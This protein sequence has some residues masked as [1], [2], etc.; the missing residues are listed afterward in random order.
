MGESWVV[1]HHRGSK[2]IQV[3]K[4]TKPAV[5]IGG[6][7]FW[8]TQLE[9]NVSMY[10]SI[11]TRSI[12]ANLWFVNWSKLAI[13]SKEWTWH[14]KSQMRIAHSFQDPWHSFPCFSAPEGISCSWFLTQA[15]LKRAEQ[16]LKLSDSFG[17]DWSQGSPGSPWGDDE[18][19][20][21]FSS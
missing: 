4:L 11:Y 3:C 8:C 20:V 6:T 2:W 14:L 17:Q 9:G 15:R 5:H 16:T 19:F 7:G 21:R 1:S 13:F 10:I 18:C 12:T